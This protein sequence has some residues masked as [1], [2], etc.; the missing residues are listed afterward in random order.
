MLN[1][2]RC[3]SL[4]SLAQPVLKI[5]LASLLLASAMIP[6]AL[7]APEESASRVARTVGI[8]N[9][10]FGQAVVRA[11]SGAI[12]QVGSP[13]T[14]PVEVAY[15]QDLATARVVVGYD[16]AVLQVAGFQRN[17]AFSVTVPNQEFDRDE[18]GVPDAVN[19]AVLSMDGLSAG[20]GSPLNLAN[21][22]WT[23]VGGPDPGTTSTLVVEVPEFYG[24]DNGVLFPISVSAENGQV[25]VGIAQVRISD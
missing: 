17:P 1:Q 24:D 6:I 3:W 15:V 22:A 10:T 23:V 16:P 8:T 5:G 2:R 4:R 9:E 25:T 13:I 12:L 11:G 14:L 21:I 7:S 18:D 20:E 19:F